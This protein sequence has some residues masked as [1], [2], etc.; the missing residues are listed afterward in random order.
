MNSREIEHAPDWQGK[1][2]GAVCRQHA[3]KEADEADEDRQLPLD[4]RRAGAAEL[5]R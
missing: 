5:I 1:S 3:L 4:I 2:D